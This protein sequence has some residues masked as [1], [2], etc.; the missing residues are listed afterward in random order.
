MKKNIILIF[1]TILINRAAAQSVVINNDGSP[2]HASAMLD[3]KRTDKGLLISRVA[4]LS[5]SEITTINSP[6]V[7]LPVY[8]TN[9][10]LSDGDGFYFRNGGKWNKLLKETNLDSLSWSLTGNAGTNPAN[11]FIGTTDGKPLVFKTNNI[12]SGKIEPGP[13]NVF[14]GQS[15]GLNITS[16][17]NNSFFGHSAGAAN[18]SGSNNLFAGSL[19]GTSTTTGKGNAFVGHATGKNNTEGCRHQ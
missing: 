16:G 10:A 6:R 2:P 13:N 7:S 9:G 15:A 8:H 5:D 17:N 4:L 19:S 1:C 11:D 14:F 3:I 12:L 18:T